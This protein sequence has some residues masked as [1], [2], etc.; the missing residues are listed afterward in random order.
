VPIDPNIIDPAALER[1]QEWGGPK[2]S[3]EIVRLFLDHGPS[4]MDQIR[5]A[6]DE[7][8]LEVPERGAHSLKSSAANVGALHVQ[9]VA[10]DLEL[11]ASD[12]DQDSRVLMEDYLGDFGCE[13]LQAGSGADGLN[14]TRIHQPD[15]V[16][17]DLH[18][19]GV[20]GWE[21]L[22]TL[23]G[24]PDVKHIP[25]V[26]ASIAANEGRGR[27]FGAVD[28]LTKPIER[29]DL[30]RV[31]WQQL[32][33][34]HGRRVLVVEDDPEIQA[35][36]TSA[37]D[38]YDLDFECVSSGEEALQSLERETP[39]AV[40]LDLR[41]PVMDGFEFLERM[42]ESRYHKGLPVIVITVKRLTPDEE[43]QLADKASAVVVKDQSFVPRIRTVLSTIFPEAALTSKAETPGD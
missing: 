13:V 26:I 1:L 25:V 43:A 18:M 35:L 32:V 42:R 33:N 7:E 30:M 4:R 15:L 34:Q 2:L 39:A 24:D 17:L 9:K 12:G 41:M 20:D 14:M 29:A 19:P 11:A 40:L 8:D 22:R 31:L 36:I 5:A 6:I 23:K 37:F 21:V 16:T 10:S 38:G 27:L 3:N 28:L